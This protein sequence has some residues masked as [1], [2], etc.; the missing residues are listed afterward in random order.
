MKD[1]SYFITRIDQ[2]ER[3]ID[4]Y[5]SGVL[6]EKWKDWFRKHQAH[7]TQDKIAV[8]IMDNKHEFLRKYLNA[9]KL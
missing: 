8:E 2:L 1:C 4:D 5:E 3:L 6:L 7:I 9:R